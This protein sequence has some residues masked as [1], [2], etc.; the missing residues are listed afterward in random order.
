[1]NAPLSRQAGQL[2]DRVITFKAAPF[3]A[4]VLVA[5]DRELTID[6]DIV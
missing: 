2:G 3:A 6:I 1:M 4:Y 5:W